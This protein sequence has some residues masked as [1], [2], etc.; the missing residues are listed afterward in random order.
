M[1]KYRLSGDVCHPGFVE[2]ECSEEEL[3]EMMGE[4]NI[5]LIDRP[6][7][8]VVDEDTSIKVAAFIPDGGL[9]DEDGA[10]LELP[11]EA[12]P[13]E[14]SNCLAGMKCPK[15][16][17][18]EPFDIHA[19]VICKVYDDGTDEYGDVEWQDDSLC[20]CS[21]CNALGTVAGFQG[22]PAPI[23][24]PCFGIVVQLDGK[25]G[26]RI[27]SEL[28]GD[29]KAAQ[30]DLAGA[31]DGIESM[32]LAHACAGIDITT[33]AYLEGIETAVEKVYNTWG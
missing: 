28:H 3:R 10:D 21:K 27:D 29:V 18:L 26:G 14:N 22:M 5:G 31:L 12:L 19:E 24:L 4:E 2:V 32:I 7:M 20:R 33:P 11:A 6:Q 1:P 23:K 9:F 25:G 16:G 30:R 15:C 13:K 17:S 8:R